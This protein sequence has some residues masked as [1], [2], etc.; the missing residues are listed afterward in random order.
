MTQIRVTEEARR[1]LEE[2]IEVLD[3][4]D[5]T[6]PRVRDCLRTLIVAPESGRGLLPPFAPARWVIG[7]WRWMI[8]VYLYD[9]A[10]D[11]ATVIAIQDGRSRDAASSTSM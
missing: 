4:P 5:D 8:L 7:P 2:L 9:D 1:N 3:L 6:R 11:V 10:T